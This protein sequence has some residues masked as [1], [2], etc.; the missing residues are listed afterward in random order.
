M[1][2][3]HLKQ[4]NQQTLLR[5]I[6][7]SGIGLH[8]GLHAD[9]KIVPSD[10]DT[11]ITFI[12]TDIEKNNIIKAL[13]SNVSATNLSTTISNENK[14]SVSTIEHLM[15]ALSGMHIDNAKVFING[16]EI[17]I[18]DGSS[19][20][21]VE[22]IE[23]AQLIDQKKSR[24]IIKVKKKVE[25][26]KKDSYVSISPNNQFSIDFEIDF[27][28]HL[29]NKQARQLQLVNGNYKSDI[30]SARTFG[31]EKD[32]NELR[33]NGFALG[34]S[35]ENAVVVGDK[36]I[37]NKEGL[38]FQD[39]FVRHKILD[40]IGDLYLAGAPIQGYFCGKKSGHYLNNELLRKLLSDK[41]NFE[42]IKI[43][44]SFFLA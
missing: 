16:P 12:R 8:K 18:M 30:S 29:I 34:G 5:E 17:P 31:F 13:W 1:I 10:L 35:L 27:E 43:F 26:R 7:F 21:F 40:S 36:D 41:S 42:L 14:I 39:E 2:A 3:S 25:V 33:L 44:K 9:I 6:E 22:L 11:G 23:N 28:S 24:K 15:S 4:I 38:R 32:V 20:P 19:R 37:L